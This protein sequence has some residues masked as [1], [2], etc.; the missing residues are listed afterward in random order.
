MLS[1]AVNA[2]KALTVAV[3]ND[4]DF[5]TYLQRWPKF[6]ELIPKSQSRF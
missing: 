3:F 4:G 2:L 5:W 6:E 1:D